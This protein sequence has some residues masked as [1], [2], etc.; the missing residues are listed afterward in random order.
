MKQQEEKFSRTVI[1]FK[2]V[3]SIVQRKSIHRP[4]VGW[5]SRNW[6]GYALTSVRTSNSRKNKNEAGSRRNQKSNTRLDR[7]VRSIMEQRMKTNLD[8]F[9]AFQE[10]LSR[11][12]IRQKIKQALEDSLFR[13]SRSGVRSSARGS[14][15][16]IQGE[17]VVPRLKPT[18]G[19]AY[20]SAWIGIDGFNNSSLIQVGT[21][22]SFRNG[23]P[24][25]YAWWE[26]LPS[27]S[28]SIP[29]AA[30]TVAPGDRI[31]AIIRKI[32]AKRWQIRLINLTKGEQFVTTQRYSGPGRS[33][34]WIVEA[35]QVNG[36]IAKL[37]R[38]SPI[39]FVRA[40]INGRAAHFTARNGGAMSVN[41]R[42]IATPSLPNA[43]RDGFV[44]ARG[45]KRPAV[46]KPS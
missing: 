17:W 39:R 23:H 29:T 11:Q 40:R 36:S 3:S 18:P 14:F 34:E 20:S 31:R 6:A 38:F 26:I 25:Y 44:V 24:V 8:E 10:G 37:A 21:E 19:N 33:A 1:S 28:R 30:F 41:G 22:H 4:G 13:I 43:S 45:A 2:P 16:S 42:Q 27:A 46:P 15:G 32:A 5:H 35:P 7:L 9:V 12:H